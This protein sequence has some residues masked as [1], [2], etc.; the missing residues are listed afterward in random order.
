MAIK[1]DC[2]HLKFCKNVSCIKCEYTNRFLEKVT[3]TGFTRIAHSNISV[4][5]V[6]SR[7]DNTFKVNPCVFTRLAKY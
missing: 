7:T 3:I 5:H 2:L 1:Q 6:G 4:F